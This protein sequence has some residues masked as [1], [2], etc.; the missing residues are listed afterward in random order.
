MVIGFIVRIIMTFGYNATSIPIYSISTLLI[1]VAPCA[2]IAQ[3]YYVLPKMAV[4][5]D[6]ALRVQNQSLSSG[7][8]QGRDDYANAN[9]GKKND[10][11]ADC[12]F[13]KSRLI[14]RIFLTSDVVTFI[15]QLAG[16]GMTAVQSI[17]EI[18]DKVWLNCSL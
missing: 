17:A 7:Y 1:L 6:E 10:I 13:L 5:L 14:G 8:A 3:N 16:S 9:K 11:A 18:G 4:W 12:L 2:F 15:T